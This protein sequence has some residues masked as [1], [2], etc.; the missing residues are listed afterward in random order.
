MKSSNPNN[1][2]AN[3]ILYKTFFLEK[4]IMVQTGHTSGKEIY[5]S[6]WSCVKN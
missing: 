3:V 1:E 5:T 6:T 4:N 2:Y